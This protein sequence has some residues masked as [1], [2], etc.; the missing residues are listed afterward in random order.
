MI[1][2]IFLFIGLFFAS[3]FVYSAPT[4]A[5]TGL[6]LETEVTG[7][8]T[9]TEVSYH[10]ESDSSRNKEGRSYEKERELDLNQV[11]KYETKFRR[12]HLQK[13]VS[14]IRGG[15]VKS[16]YF[17]VVQVTPPKEPESSQELFDVLSRV[18][19]GDFNG[20]DFV[21]FGTLT[22]IDAQ[23]QVNEIIGSNAYSYALEIQVVADFSLINTVTN[24]V[25]ASFSAL[26]E[27]DDMKLTKAGNK[28][29]PSFA[30]AIRNVSKS[31]A[32]DVLMNIEDQSFEV[33]LK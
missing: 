12:S 30:K 26:G 14:D 8:F 17:D 22:A 23:D 9:E 19:A 20:A 29:R 24:E 2:S 31:L 7:Y 27:G 11:T 4:I 6:A 32:E 18:K 25:I 5:V 13:F 33:K 10:A 1:K 15:L 16:E 21:L 3:S 28:V